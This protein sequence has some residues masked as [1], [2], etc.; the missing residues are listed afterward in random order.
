MNIVDNTLFRV[1]IVNRVRGFYYV[2]TL[3]EYYL[4]EALTSTKDF[5]VEIYYEQKR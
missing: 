1:I 3:H 5:S 4:K 2:S